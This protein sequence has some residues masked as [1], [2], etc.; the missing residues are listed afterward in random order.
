MGTLLERGSW[1]CVCGLAGAVAMHGYAGG[2]CRGSVTDW[3]TGTASW[4]WE[5]WT[6]R[7]TAHWVGIWRTTRALWPLDGIDAKTE[8]IK[9]PAHVYVAKR[10]RPRSTPEQQVGPTKRSTSG[11]K[12]EPS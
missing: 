4:H 6:T 12:L 8:P 11:W 5:H 3:G 10:D 9:G 7:R 1:W 2:K